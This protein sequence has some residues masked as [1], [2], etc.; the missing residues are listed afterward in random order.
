MKKY[1]VLFI[2]S[3]LT[4]VGCIQDSTKQAV[5]SDSWDDDPLIVKIYDDNGGYETV[6]EITDADKIEKLI[7]T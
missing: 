1:I 4:L 5:Y 3:G 7:K 2:V 6:N